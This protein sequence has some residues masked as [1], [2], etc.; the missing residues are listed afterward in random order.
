[1]ESVL[2]VVVSALFF[3]GIALIFRAMLTLVPALRARRRE[4]E[5]EREKERGE[6]K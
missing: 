5:R 4:R 3:I 6:D 1:M 2:R